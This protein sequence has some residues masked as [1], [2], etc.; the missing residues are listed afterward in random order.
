MRRARSRRAPL[1]LTVLLLPIAASGVWLFLG[2]KATREPPPPAAVNGHSIE[3]AQHGGRPSAKTGPPGIS[4]IGGQKI[5]VRFQ[6]P[7]TA[8]LLFDVPARQGMLGRHP[9]RPPPVP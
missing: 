5:R 2:S 8:A 4:L 9:L 7:P 6:H 3:R 1:V